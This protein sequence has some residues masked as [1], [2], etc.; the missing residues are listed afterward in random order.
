MLIMGDS[1]IVRPKHEAQMF[2]LLGGG[3]PGDLTS[4]PNSQLAILPVTTHVT[5][6]ER[7]NWLFSMISKFLDLPIPMQE[8]D[9]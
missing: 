7:T 4:L 2:R 3:V 8:V 5:L 9:D 6:V 1:D